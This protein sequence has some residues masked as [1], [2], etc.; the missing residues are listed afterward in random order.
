MPDEELHATTEPSIDGSDVRYVLLRTK[1]DPYG[2]YD[3]RFANYELELLPPKTDRDCALESALVA[4]DENAVWL[5]FTGEIRFVESTEGLAKIRINEAEK[6]Q[7]TKTE[8]RV[9]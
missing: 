6:E 5:V 1:L 4:A 2:Q 3:P 8:E 9:K 7:Q